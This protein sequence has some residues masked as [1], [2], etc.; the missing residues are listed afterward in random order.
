MF[1][2]LSPVIFSAAIIASTFCYPASSALAQSST[3][4]ARSDKQKIEWLISRANKLEKQNK[5]RKG[6]IA[7]LTNSVQ[8]IATTAQPGIPGVAG[9]Q[10]LV[11]PQGPKGDQGDPGTIS[12]DS[13]ESRHI[14][15]GAVDNHHLNVS[16]ATFS[17]DA[18]A[19]TGGFNVAKICQL[20]SFTFCALTKTA[21]KDTTNGSCKLTLTSTATPPRWR[22]EVQVA[23]PQAP[24]VTSEVHCDATCF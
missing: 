15:A 21:L 14:Q 20:S 8:N 3:T 17:C 2:F 18:S 11:G 19:V 24:G 6:E 22:L 5:T 23:A 10:G 7:A 4:K 12:D 9:P 13:V 16:T 1:R